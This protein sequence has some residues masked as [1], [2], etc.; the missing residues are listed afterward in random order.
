MPKL[1][2][3]LSVANFMY[4]NAKYYNILSNAIKNINTPNEHLCHKVEK[5]LEFP[6]SNKIIQF[7]NIK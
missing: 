6:T 1:I 7:Y 3:A 2:I 5:Q 4:K